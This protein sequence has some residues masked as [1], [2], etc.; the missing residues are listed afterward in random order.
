MFF[1][2]SAMLV[3]ARVVLGCG[4]QPTNAAPDAKAVRAPKPRKLRRERAVALVVVMGSSSVFIRLRSRLLG[5]PAVVA[6]LSIVGR[7]GL[8]KTYIQVNN[9]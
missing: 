7:K 2:S 6:C 5:L 9:G 1:G 4:A 3:Y 8:E